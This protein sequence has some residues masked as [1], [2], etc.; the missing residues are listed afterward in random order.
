MSSLALHLCPKVALWNLRWNTM[1]YEAKLPEEERTFV[2]L[3][4][5]WSWT[6][7]LA[8]PVGTYLTWVLAYWLL[9]FVLA[10]RRIKDRNYDTLYAYYNR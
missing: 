7:F 4:D 8:A 5:E 6:K 2:N 9:M 10:G 1:P 3:D